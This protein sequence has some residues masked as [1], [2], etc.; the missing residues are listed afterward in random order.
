MA[1]AF[2]SGPASFARF[3]ASAARGLRADASASAIFI[4]ACHPTAE[5]SNSLPKLNSS[6]SQ[7]IANQVKKLKS[8]LRLGSQKCLKLL[9]S[10]NSNAVNG[11]PITGPALHCCVPL[12]RLHEVHHLHGGQRCTLQQP[13]LKNRLKSC[14]IC[15]SKRIVGNQEM[16]AGCSSRILT[17][18]LHEFACLEKRVPL[19][20]RDCDMR[21]QGRPRT[22]PSFPVLHLQEQGGSD[23]GCCLGLC[24]DRHSSS[25]L[26]RF[27]NSIH[28]T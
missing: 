21:G 19:F 27:Q 5:I 13:G 14:N 8:K 25:L 6:E 1:S 23:R 28:L 2:D 7:M 9:Q 12:L 3:S 18:S 22:F 4:K 15:N 10:P 24:E 20:L 16:V 11:H 17:S 26:C